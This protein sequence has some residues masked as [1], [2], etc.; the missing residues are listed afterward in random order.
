[1]NADLHRRTGESLVDDC[2][3]DRIAQLSQS[4]DHYEADRHLLDRTV[5]AQDAAGPPYLPRAQRERS[6]QRIRVGYP[7][8][9]GMA[10]NLHRLLAGEILEGERPDR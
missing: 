3:I 10:G 4:R 5:P 8:F 6:R 2:L 7:N 1:M 9:D